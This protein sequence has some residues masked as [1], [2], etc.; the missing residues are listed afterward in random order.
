MPRLFVRQIGFD[1]KKNT[2]DEPSGL[3]TKSFFRLRINSGLNSHT[4]DRLQPNLHAP[5]GACQEG[6]KA[7][8]SYDATFLGS[9]DARNH[10]LNDIWTCC[11]QSSLSS[12]PRDESGRTLSGMIIGSLLEPGALLLPLPLHVRGLTP[13]SPPGTW[14]HWSRAA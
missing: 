1:K 5:S 3:I 4:S 8:K 7:I 13:P 11:H 12:P 9:S 14:R 2:G 6:Y 10:Q